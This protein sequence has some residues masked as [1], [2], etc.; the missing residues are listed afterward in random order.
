MFR[1]SQRGE[2]IDDADM[3]EG[4]REIVRGRPPG[5]YDVIGSWSGTLAE[6]DHFSRSRLLDSFG[7]FFNVS[8]C[9]ALFSSEYSCGSCA[10]R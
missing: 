9:F 8:C 3:I 6:I 4:P 5:R 7:R 1:M 10:A 2:S